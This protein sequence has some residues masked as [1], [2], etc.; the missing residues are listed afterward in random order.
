[1]C[2]D[3][4]AKLFI[5]LKN[6]II[7]TSSFQL[8]SSGL[9]YSF[10]FLTISNKLENLRAIQEKSSRLHQFSTFFFSRAFPSLRLIASN[11]AR[12]ARIGHH[13]SPVLLENLQ[14]R[15]VVTDPT[16]RRVGKMVES[17]NKLINTTKEMSYRT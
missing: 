16:W 11:Y 1:M 5:D 9:K 8:C 2:V 10:H 15:A 13:S 17:V 14:C 4:S 12:N 3:E 6:H 7:S